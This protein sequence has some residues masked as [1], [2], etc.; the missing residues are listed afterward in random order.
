MRDFCWSLFL[1]RHDCNICYSIRRIFLIKNKLWSVS[2][3]VPNVV[4][5]HIKILKPPTYDSQTS[6]NFQHPSLAGRTGSPY[7]ITLLEH[8]S[9]CVLQ[10]EYCLFARRSLYCWDST[11]SRQVGDR[12]NV[13]FLWIYGDALGASRMWTQQNCPKIQIDSKR[14]EQT[15]WIAAPEGVS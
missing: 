13:C 6:V 3:T 8:H 1:V 11:S 4:R 5:A 9:L 7:S 15:T 12:C 10:S 14:M 2:H